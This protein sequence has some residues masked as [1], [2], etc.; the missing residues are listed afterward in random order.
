MLRVINNNIIDTN[1]QGQECYDNSSLDELEEQECCS[2]IKDD[3]YHESLGILL[4]VFSVSNGDELE[5]EDTFDL[6]LL[7]PHFT[8]W[9]DFLK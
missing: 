7:I 3:N 4:E 1:M 9:D 8:S 2:Q 5:K 6:S